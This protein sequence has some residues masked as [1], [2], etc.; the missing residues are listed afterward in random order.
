VHV[1]HCIN[2]VKVCI[3]LPPSANKDHSWIKVSKGFITA[4]TALTP[5]DWDLSFRW[6]STTNREYTETYDSYSI[7]GLSFNRL[8]KISNKVIVWILL[9]CLKN[10]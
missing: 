2:L 7:F 9:F 10:V 5:E 3:L 6:N 8:G 4:V 1:V